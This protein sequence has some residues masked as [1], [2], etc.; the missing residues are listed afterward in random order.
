MLGRG[1]TE[2]SWSSQAILCKSHI[3]DQADKGPAESTGEN[4]ASNPAHRRGPLTRLTSGREGWHGLS[5]LSHGLRVA[6]RTQIPELPF[7][8]W[9][10]HRPGQAEDSSCAL[11]GTQE[12]RLQCASRLHDPWLQG[13][14]FKPS[15]ML[16][17]KTWCWGQALAAL[18]QT[19]LE[20]EKLEL[21]TRALAR[22]LQ[23]I[24]KDDR[25][26]LQDCTLNSIDG[27]CGVLDDPIFIQ[28]LQEGSWGR[29]AARFGSGSAWGGQSW[30]SSRVRGKTLAVL[31]GTSELP[32]L[33]ATES[34]A[35]SIL[36]KSHHQDHRWS[37]QDIAAHLRRLAWIV[38]ATRLAK[39]CC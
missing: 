32:I 10:H 17:N 5:D 29:K 24:L 1:H 21:S 7:E 13:P 9:P 37:P 31:L 12:D 4:H 3:G 16:S 30:V 2:S 20:R 15:V 39:K 26:A 35:Q 6:T 33:L 38:G 22:V 28:D 34:L 14:Y 19:A 8:Q 36:Q 23:A 25:E 27:V 11:G 18:T